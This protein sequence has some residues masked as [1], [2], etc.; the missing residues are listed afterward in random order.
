M[1]IFKIKSD[2]SE[3][4]FLNLSDSFGEALQRNIHGF[5]KRSLSFDC[6][7]NMWIELIWWDSMTSAQTALEIAPKTLEFKQYCAALEEEGE[8]AV[9]IHL[10]ELT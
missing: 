5:I 7:Q 10:R 4:D 9:I 3:K 1:V 6:S 8:A 2:V